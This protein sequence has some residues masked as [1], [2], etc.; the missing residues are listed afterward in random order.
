V[1]N[2]NNLRTE[3]VAKGRIQLNK[4]T[5]IQREDCVG[6]VK[7]KKILHTLVT[8]YSKTIILPH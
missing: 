3:G 5:Q 7:H 2:D 8:D 4:S 1:N 6:T